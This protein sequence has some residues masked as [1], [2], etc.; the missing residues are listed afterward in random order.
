MGSY[1]G[2]GDAAAATC[3]ADAPPL[4]N[5]TFEAAF[6]HLQDDLSAQHN[7]REACEVA[8]HAEHEAHEDCLDAEQTFKK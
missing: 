4:S 3:H 5:A 8:Q 2:R 6:K 1:G 7:M